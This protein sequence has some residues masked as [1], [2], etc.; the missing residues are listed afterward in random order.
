[1]P[2]DSQSTQTMHTAYIYDAQGHRNKEAGALSAYQDINIQGESDVNG[3]KYLDIGNGQYLNANNV[4]GMKR[5]MTND[6]QIY[7]NKGNLVPNAETLE[8]GS[9]HTTYGQP[10]YLNGNMM[11]RVGVGQY[12]KQ[13][14]VGPALGYGDGKQENYV[15]KKEKSK[16][17]GK[18]K[19]K[20]KGKSKTRSKAKAKGK[21]KGRAKKHTKSKAKG[22]KRPT[23]SAKA[24][25]KVIYDKEVSADMQ[26]ATAQ[27]VK[28]NRI[29]AP[30][31]QDDGGKNQING[32]GFESGYDQESDLADYIDPNTHQ[33]L[34]PN[35][36]RYYAIPK[37]PSPTGNAKQYYFSDLQAAEREANLNAPNAQDR[38]MLVDLWAPGAHP[39]A[40]YNHGGEVPTDNSLQQAA[41]AGNTNTELQGINIAQVNP[42]LAQAN[43]ANPAGPQLGA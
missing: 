21:V 35:M 26:N 29:Y 13:D 12:V 6:A 19:S 28:A 10:L 3:K 27:D 9:V 25:E 16:A 31:F 38:G 34:D 20:A 18:T 42:S 30:N 23:K 14:D 4:L 41:Q 39:D 1:M 8:A 36:G 7:N 40:R 32:Q 5:E 11:Y 2:E 17:K 43:A 24:R 37:I 15:E 22:K 33:K